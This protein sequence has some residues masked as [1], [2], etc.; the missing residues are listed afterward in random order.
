MDWVGVAELTSDDDRTD[1]VTRKGRDELVACKT[2]GEHVCASWC[3]S[4]SSAS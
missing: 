1:I 2:M 4:W 3:P